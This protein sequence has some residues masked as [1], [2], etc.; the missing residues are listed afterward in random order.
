[1]IIQFVCTLNR[2]KK[3]LAVGRE[4]KRTQNRKPCSHRTGLINY[5]TLVRINVLCL[6][7]P[8]FICATLQH[9]F[10]YLMALYWQIS[11]LMLGGFLNYHFFLCML[12]RYLLKETHKHVF[13]RLR[14]LCGVAFSTFQWK[15]HWELSFL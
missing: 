11:L 4:I 10:F 14:F 2:S 15:C 3:A 9:S 12:W 6:N 7:I 13:A 5:K 1:M 8:Y